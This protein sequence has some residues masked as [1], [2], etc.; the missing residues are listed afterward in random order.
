MSSSADQLAGAIPTPAP[1]PDLRLIR[2]PEAVSE[3]EQLQQQAAE[4]RARTR[5]EAD[6]YA[7]GYFRGISEARKR[8]E[9]ELAVMRAELQ[10]AEELAAARRQGDVDAAVA[11]LHTA[12]EGLASRAQELRHEIAS[13]AADLAALLVEALL[14]RELGRLDD[15]AAAAGVVR[16]VVAALADLAAESSGHGDRVDA[17]VRVA[18]ALLEAVRDEDRT[19]L[20]SLG[21]Q[22]MGDA[23]LARDDAVV[24]AGSTRVDLRLHSTLHHVQ[25]ALREDLP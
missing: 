8:A 25:A 7:S 10:Q 15:E 16:R 23:G 6:G 24:D 4:D 17:R 3:A 14:G 5:A 22:L 12:A 9:T 18:P 11:A 19:T 1:V 20:A 13:E 2:V 21:V